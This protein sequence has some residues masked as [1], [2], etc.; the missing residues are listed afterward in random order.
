MRASP[1][2][3]TA[4]RAGEVFKDC[5]DCPEMVVV[6]AGSFIMGGEEHVS[7]RPP[8]PVALKS[9]ALGKT[10]ITQG[11]WKAVMGSN[12]S[13]FAQ[14]GDGCPVEQV[15]W[16]DAQEF[17]KKLSAKT[18]M[19]YR[20]PS[21]AEWEYAARS[22][23]SS[24]YSWGDDVGRNNANCAVCGSQWDLIGTAPVGTFQRNAYG[25]FD[26]HGN[27]SEWVDD[28]WHDYYASPPSDGTAWKTQCTG[29]PRRVRRGGAYYNTAVALRSTDRGSNADDF[30]NPGIGLRVARNF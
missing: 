10:E 12:P 14:C 29:S 22:G 19:Q 3:S 16:S 30:R 23:S 5:A 2:Q 17:A 6:P 8:H 15:S 25:L 26:M 13:K 28:C 24:R 21:E 18:G 1:P 9:F 7:E 11:Q 4:R 20:L 27:V